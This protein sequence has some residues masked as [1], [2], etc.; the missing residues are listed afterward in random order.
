MSKSKDRVEGRAPRGPAFAVTLPRTE[1]APAFGA[2]LISTDIAIGSPDDPRLL[3]PEEA[4]Q[5]A[6]YLVEMA[7]L[8]GHPS[9]DTSFATERAKARE[10]GKKHLTQK[11]PTTAAPSTPKPTP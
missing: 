2:E 3:D 5:L 4:V 10:A 11:F 8:A 1:G 9:A 7:Q 6:A